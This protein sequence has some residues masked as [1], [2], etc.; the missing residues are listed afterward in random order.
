LSADAV[1]KWAWAANGKVNADFV[2]HIAMTQL[3]VVSFDL[4]IL[5]QVE[6]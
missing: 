3:G 1:N 4:E 2:G 5:T 6:V